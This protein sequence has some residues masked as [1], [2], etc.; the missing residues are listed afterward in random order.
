VFLDQIKENEVA[1]A[2]GT[3]VT[4]EKRVKSSGGKA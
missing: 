1:G 2:Y 3:H 4:G